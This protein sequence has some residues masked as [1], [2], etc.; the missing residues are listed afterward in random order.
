M[1]HYPVRQ[2]VTA[3]ILRVNSQGRLEL[4]LLGR[5]CG[6]LRRRGQRHGKLQCQRREAGD[7]G[8]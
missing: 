1:E 4:L 3:F 8:Q 7:G 2:T 5:D 6:L